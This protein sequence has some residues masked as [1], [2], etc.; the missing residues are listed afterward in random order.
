MPEI[1]Y[2]IVGLDF[3]HHYLA[4]EYKLGSIIILSRKKP[5]VAIEPELQLY[6]KY[7]TLAVPSTFVAFDLHALPDF[8]LSNDSQDLKF[9]DIKDEVDKIMYNHIAGKEKVT[10]IARKISLLLTWSLDI[11]VFPFH[12][13]TFIEEQLYGKDFFSE[14]V[15]DLLTKEPTNTILVEN[16]AEKIRSMEEE[17]SETIGESYPVSLTKSPLKTLY[18]CIEKLS[19]KDERV[20]WR[21]SFAYRKGIQCLEFQQ[22]EDPIQDNLSD[23]WVFLV[24]SVEA[25]F[26]K[27]TAVCPN[28]WEVIKADRC[29]YCDN[30]KPSKECEKCGEMVPTSRTKVIDDF[31]SGYRKFPKDFPKELQKKVLKIGDKLRKEMK[32]YQK[33]SAYVHAGILEHL[34]SGDFTIFPT[35]KWND[36]RNLLSKLRKQVRSGISIWLFWKSGGHFPGII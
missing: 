36:T 25:L 17:P 16:L 19:K 34:E 7:R 13:W 29:D 14:V 20:F 9:K 22:F 30:F 15:P 1:R 6:P 27:G 2:A 12:T 10:Q 33:R 5:F 24:T 21:S 32:V 11:P 31:L 35:S 3:G 18:D 26:E 23:P 28:C 4:E 8:L